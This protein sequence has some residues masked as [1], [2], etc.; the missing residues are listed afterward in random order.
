MIAGAALDVF[1]NEPSINK[2]LL[3]LPN[4][5]LTPHIAGFTEEANKAI[6]IEAVTRFLNE[7]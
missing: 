4:V 6:C 1:E 3:A 5:F 2:R 7:H